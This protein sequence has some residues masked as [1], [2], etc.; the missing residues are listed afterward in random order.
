[1]RNEIIDRRHMRCFICKKEYTVNGFKFLDIVNIDGHTYFKFKCL[2]CNEVNDLSLSEIN[3]FSILKAFE[4]QK[5][6]IIYEQNIE[7]LLSRL[8]TIYQD[9]S[10]EEDFL[11]SIVSMDEEQERDFK[12][13]FDGLIFDF[14]DSERI[15]IKIMI[16]W[17]SIIARKEAFAIIIN[18]LNDVIKE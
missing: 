5:N 13:F 1:M 17:A 15:L 6:N 10:K 12:T 8:N 11:K 14:Q 4:Y 18:N 16:E 3:K 7:G 2:A 9:I